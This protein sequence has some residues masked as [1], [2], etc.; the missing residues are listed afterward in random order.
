PLRL[1]RE[2]RRAG[3]AKALA[4]PPNALAREAELAGVRHLHRE[5]RRALL[6]V[7]LRLADLEGVRGHGGES[8]RHR[9]IGA[10]HQRGGAVDRAAAGLGGGAALVR[11]GAARRVAIEADDRIASNRGDVDALAV[12]ADRDASGAEEPG[13]SVDRAAAAIQGYAVAKNQCAI[14]R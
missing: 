7:Q 2:L 3:A 4:S 1:D 13:R 12:G 6:A 10:E 9:P 14:R 8:R 5:L 11:E